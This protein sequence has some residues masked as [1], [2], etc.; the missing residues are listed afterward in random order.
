[1]KVIAAG[2]ASAFT[3]LV[4]RHIDRIVGVASRMMG[5]QADGE[6][7]AQEALMRVWIFASKWHPI[8]RGGKAPFTTWLYRIVLNLVIDRKRRRE[9]IPLE[10][11]YEPL[12][13]S[14]GAFAYIYGQE[15][16]RLVSAAVSRLPER[17]RRALK[18]C[19]FEG[20]TNIDACQIMSVSDSAVESLLFRA[21]RNLRVNLED[22]YREL[23]SY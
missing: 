1:M 18:L 17:Q 2:D 12:D 8:C 7:I 5:S 21:R 4:E 15:L 22:L 9:A 14:D 23:S 16:S 10:E 19:S 3:Q 13:D 6:E 11:A 20:R